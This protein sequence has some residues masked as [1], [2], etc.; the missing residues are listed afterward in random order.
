M[1]RRFVAAA[2]LPSDAEI[3]LNF[4]R[5]PFSPQADGSLLVKGDLHISGRCPEKLPDL[6]MVVVEGSFDCSGNQLASLEGAPTTVG[7]DF[8]CQDNKLTTLQGSPAKIRGTFDCGRNKLKSLAGGPSC[9][10]NFFCHENRLTTLE[11]APSEVTG[12]FNCADNKIRSLKGAP[13][14]VGRDFWCYNN[15]LTSLEGAPT[16][17][18]GGFLCG[19]NKLTSLDYGPQTKSDMYVCKGNRLRSLDAAPE[20][21]RRLATDF[22]TYTSLEQVP[23]HLRA[24]RGVI[25][26]AG[27]PLPP[28]IRSAIV[29]DHALNVGKPLALCKRR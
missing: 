10:H 12:T 28:E 15:A 2:A 22:G 26:R 14:K 17:V 11:Y 8:R 24:E 7:K 25:V 19:N 3:A 29:L 20:K 6:S 21:I 23:Q 5:I 9:V 13:E 27:V 4:W 16:E 1:K 18:P